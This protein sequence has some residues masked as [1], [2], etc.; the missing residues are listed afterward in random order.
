MFFGHVT[1]AGSS[2]QTF[3]CTST[4]SSLLLRRLPGVPVPVHSPSVV[5]RNPHGKC[6][7]DG[8]GAINRLYPPGSRSVTQLDLDVT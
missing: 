4:V 7:A 3:G 2:H 6:A 5:S 1:L 8:Y